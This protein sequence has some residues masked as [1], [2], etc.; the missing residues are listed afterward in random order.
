MKGKNADHWRRGVT[1][2]LISRRSSSAILG[3]YHGT[4]AGRRFPGRSGERAQG[5]RPEGRVPPRRDGHRDPHPASPGGGGPW[6][7]GQ[8]VLLR[9]PQARGARRRLRRR[10]L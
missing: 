2:M 7:R 8:H 9:E 6:V 5:R 3:G 10:S 4:P 1:H